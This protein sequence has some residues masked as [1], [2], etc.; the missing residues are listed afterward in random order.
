MYSAFDYFLKQ[1]TPSL[2]LCTPNKVPVASLKGAYTITNTLRFN[3]ISELSFEFPQSLDKGVT[4]L[5]AYALLR[6]KMLVLVENVGYY[7]INECPETST[8]AT[9]VKSVT[10]QSLE[11]GMLYKRMTGFE[12]DPVMLY[13]PSNSADSLLD[14]VLQ[15]FPGW[16]VAYVDPDLLTDPT[17]GNTI[18]RMFSVDNG[19]L[20]NFLIS[21]VELAYNCVFTFD[22]FNR[23]L[24]AYA[25][26]NLDTDSGAFLSFNNINKELTVTEYSD[27]L[28]TCLYC[29]GDNLDITS[30]NPLGKNC[31]YNFG[32]FKSTTWMTQDMIDAIEAWEAKTAGFQSTYA[33]YAA[34]LTNYYLE[35][36]ALKATLIEMQAEL[37]AL[38][39]T[40]E[41]QQAGKMDTS[42][43]KVDIK[44]KN[45]SINRQNELIENAQ[46]NI[47]LT[48][49]N[50]RKIIYQLSFTGKRNLERMLK[51]IS[52]IYFDFQ[53]LSTSWGSIYNANSTNPELNE[54]DLDD[55][56]ADIVGTFEYGLSDLDV[57]LTTITLSILQYPIDSSGVTNLVNVFNIFI[58]DLETLYAYL[59]SLITATDITIKLR[60]TI[61]KVQGLKDTLLY[62]S[63]FT[64]TQY[65]NLQD[66]ILENTYTNDSI[67]FTDIM[68]TSEIQAQIQLLYNE[69]VNVLSRASLPRYEIE[70]SFINVLYS[71]DYQDFIDKL[72]LGSLV[73]LEISEGVVV[74][75]ALLEIEVTYD[76]PTNFNLI[77]SNRVR[78][79]Q[80]NFQF[81]D[82]FLDSAESSSGV[83][84]L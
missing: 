33:L 19:T 43:T 12:L 41:A 77:F 35:L 44:N 22:S 5:P 47:A 26:K 9:P 1:E 36:N 69:G 8:G 21:K 82:M 10:C 30:V 80:S 53:S 23:T 13:N 37:A 72:E 15:Y 75:P 25:I 78:L 4:I 48:E 46:Y 39:T 11:S 45:I 59:N 63:N 70:G 31:I 29:F 74:Q 17:S 6:N 28:T 54:E 38:V 68:T 56:Y 71:K 32:Y 27:E 73:T 3:A 60:T 84:G 51:E 81:A 79:N 42:E 2:I 66:F 40:L 49:S 64:E 20:Y 34:D 16:T 57:I 14:I 7:I 18:R 50:M 61:I 76:D 83:S 62:E 55:A 67:V 24:S 52:N 65:L 58:D